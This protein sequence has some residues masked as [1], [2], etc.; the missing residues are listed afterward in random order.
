MPVIR[1][2]SPGTAPLRARGK[3]ALCDA[4]GEV[5]E[6]LRFFDGNGRAMSLAIRRSHE[7]LPGAKAG[8][9]CASSPL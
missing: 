4:W 9:R 1:S 6:L 8:R 7:S 2:F 5:E 3:A